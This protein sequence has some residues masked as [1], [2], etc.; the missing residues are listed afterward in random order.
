MAVGSI[1]GREYYSD[2]KKLVSGTTNCTAGGRVKGLLTT[3]T[4]LTLY[5]NGTDSAIPLTLTPTAGD[6]LPFSPQGVTFA[7]GNVFGLM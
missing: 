1:G 3:T 7:T 5:F 6:I 4:S 2:I